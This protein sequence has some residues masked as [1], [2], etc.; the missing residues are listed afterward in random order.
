MVDKSRDKPSPK[1]GTRLDSFLK[2]SGVR[3]LHLAYDAGVSRQHVY[4]LRMGSAEPT[5][6]MMVILATA[7]GRILRRKVDLV[8]MFDLSGG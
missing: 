2:A 5:R 1:A 4:R 3:P 6:H 7:A 8:E